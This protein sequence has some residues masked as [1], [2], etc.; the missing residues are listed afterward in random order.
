[1]SIM[2][3]NE[4]D[5]FGFR[6]ESWVSSPHIP[7]DHRGP[8]ERPYTPFTDASLSRPIIE[9]LET[10]VKQNP[11]KVA[12]EGPDGSFK[13]VTLWRAVCRLTEKLAS[14][15][16]GPVGVLL[17]AD[18]LYAVAVFGCVA[19]GRISVLLDATYPMQRNADIS[20][21]V[22]IRTV[23]TTS[24]A[25]IWPGVV[26]VDIT[27][28]L[29]DS[30]PVPPLP[31][32]GVDQDTP[33]FILATSG[34]TGRPKAIAHSQRTML[35][36]VRSITNALHVGPDD[37][38]ISVS[39]PS[40]LGGFTSLLTFPLAGA[41]IQMFQ[42]T[43]GGFTELLRIL[44]VRPV[45]ILRGTPSL[46]RYLIRLPDAAAAL[47]GLRIVQ[48]YGEPLL[49]HDFTQMRSCL[50]A[51]CLVRSTYGATE[52]SGL[53]WFAGEPDNHDSVRVATGTLMP[54]TQAMIIDDNGQP[55]AAGEAGELLIRSRYNAIG[56]W[57]DGRLVAG[58][59]QADQDDR[60]V[61]IYRTGDIARRDTEGVFVVLGRKDRMIKING[62]R[63]EP[64]EIETALRRSP[65]V[66]QAAIVARQLGAAT[67]LLAFVVPQKEAG[68]D[69]A[70][71]L[72]LELAAALPAFMQPARIIVV[73][74]LRLL[75]G[76]KIDEAAMLKLAMNDQPVVTG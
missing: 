11:L 53:S 25:A 26:R 20:A 33:A 29:D 66:L 55:C 47:S 73:D 35:H 13:F 28:V 59:L 60:A 18:T 27:N 50:P 64:S 1:M 23:L 52:A 56:E 8:V 16:A 14:A 54:D 9:L 75:P 72:R 4:V 76:G 21:A 49:K 62:Q 17:P 68:P 69:F 48:T 19:A 43:Q 34:S 39:S 41:A 3:L 40:T 36:W 32:A 61:R 65:D 2:S 44:A 7:P 46:I 30:T 12:M 71:Q 51:T 5:G 74:Q 70:S 6:G 24:E 10:A 58:R 22:G 15:P 42:F 38:V 57:L 45:T 67:T 63:L 37:R 31:G